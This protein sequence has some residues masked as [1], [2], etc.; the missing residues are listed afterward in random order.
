VTDHEHTWSTGPFYIKAAHAYEEP[1]FY[2]PQ[3]LVR[4]E[5]CV[6]CGI[7]RLPMDLWKH[8]GPNIAAGQGTAQHPSGM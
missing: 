5:H 7:L 2:P 4:V 3:G 8:T 6:E 1:Q